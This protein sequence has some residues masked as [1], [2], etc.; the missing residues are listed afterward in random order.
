MEIGRSIRN[1]ISIGDENGLRDVIN[2]VKDG[3][4]TL[5]QLIKN[6]GEYLIHEE[7]QVRFKGVNV[8]NEV[9]RNIPATSINRQA[10]QTLLNF[11]IDK[12][13]DLSV[14]APTLESLITLSTLNS[15]GSLE[16]NNLVNSLFN[17]LN[18][19][20]FIQPI[21]YSFYNLIDSLLNRHRS[22]LK[23]LGGSFLSGY[24]SSIKGEKDPRNLML[25][26][27]MNTVILIEFDTMSHS[28]SLFDVIFCYF[29]I[30]FKP[31]P[32][33]PYGISTDD[34]RFAL[35]QNICS[36][37]HFAQQA[38]PLLIDKLTATSGPVKRDTLLTITHA[39]PVYG[40]GHV[41]QKS[42]SLWDAISIE[43]LYSTDTHTENVAL[44]SL[45]SLIKTLYP[46]THPTEL[47]NATELPGIANLIFD[48]CHDAIKQPEK[49]KSTPAIKILATLIQ[50]SPATL[51]RPLTHST[52]IPLLELFAVPAD[53]TQPPPILNHIHAILVALSKVYA[54]Q[55]RSFL[56]DNPLNPSLKEQ[57]NNTLT[58][59]INNKP[60]RSPALAAFTQTLHINGYW[61]FIVDGVQIANILIDFV[62]DPNQDPHVRLVA[63]EGLLCLGQD[64]LHNIVL[65]SLLTSIPNSVD[66]S[67]DWKPIRAILASI[68]ALAVD[69]A[70]FED[71][72]LGVEAKMNQVSGD[73]LNLAY[74]NILLSTLLVIIEE[75][76]AKKHQDISQYTC[77]ILSKLFVFFVI[78]HP[79]SVN[80]TR[81]VATA[82][83]L[84]Q[85]I[86]R[87]FDV[88]QQQILARH[89][90]N[91]L[92][93]GY[94]QGL[95]GTEDDIIHQPPLSTNSTH[96][97]FFPLLASALI[98][99]KRE[100]NLPLAS[101]SVS[102]LQSLSEFATTLTHWSMQSAS[103]PTQ[104]IASQHLL[105]NLTNKRIESLS[106]YTT[107]LL[108]EWPERTSAESSANSIF[109][110]IIQWIAKGALCRNHALGVEFVTKLLDL[111]TSHSVYADR[112][113]GVIGAIADD[114]NDGV[115]DRKRS[116]G[117]SSL[118]H[119]QRFFDVIFPVV[120]ERYENAAS[121]SEDTTSAKYL[122][123]LAHLI[124]HM[125]KSL[126]LAKL[127]QI[128]PILLIALSLNDAAL[129]SSVIETITVLILT[130]ET[131]AHT[132][133][134]H[135]SSLITSLLSFST[136][137]ERSSVRLRV[138]ALKLLGVFPHVIR[139]D[140]L[141]QFKLQ[142]VRQLVVALD[143][144]IKLVRKEAVD[145]REFWLQV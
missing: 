108:G 43:I 35:R 53:P 120:V 59:T 40:F 111:I 36:S 56:H 95:L 2:R 136:D 96:R 24:I 33:D 97:A 113:A 76:A 98:P 134:Q 38:I 11:F 74:V 133:Q 22:T 114:S 79:G 137:S 31:P 100:V 20:Q 72:V 126:A 85:A 104:Q 121:R 132:V 65:P 103:T 117:V 118:L 135:M 32:D 57:L 4:S 112:V 140:I 73:S 119:K 138:S 105:A 63:I 27:G 143:D 47:L 86:V 26:F 18:P 52:L 92:I 141:E 123:T 25:I 127:P 67:T 3:H 89:V 39:L 124:Q 10:T 66:S 90:M 116:N 142:I 68:T 88:S 49:S 13:S 87:S 91:A 131:I 14:I 122:A 78:A 6:L 70:L 21:R 101:E 62:K 29:P 83:R 7:D 64:I 58:S 99:I 145:A 75:K 48:V 34:L 45:Q 42:R 130:E 16:A 50:S 44:D 46:D 19:S 12:L 17:T 139:K 80:E 28:E 93:N 129:R 8:L 144:P 69:G 110:I 128:F 94:W 1:Y 41:S 51:A 109:L 77:S 102:E 107:H 54:D 115:L 106:E 81:L 61:D 125:P 84:I 37:P 9:I 15:F 30:T 60:L 71:F 55:G 82:S 23:A 5:T